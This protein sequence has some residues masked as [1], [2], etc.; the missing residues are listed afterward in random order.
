MKKI[1]GEHRMA[2]FSALDNKTAFYDANS[3]FHLQLGVFKSNE[4]QNFAEFDRPFY[5]LWWNALKILI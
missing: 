3:A 2:R 5:D 1:S 4:K